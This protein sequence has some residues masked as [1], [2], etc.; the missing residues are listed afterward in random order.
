MGRLIGK[1]RAL[2]LIVEAANID[3]DRALELG[4]VNYV[5]EASS[6]EDFHAQVCDYARRF[7]PP[8][9]AS[10]AVGQIKR[11]VQSGLEMGLE[12]GLA[13][14]RELQAN[15]FRSSDAEEG[16]RAYLEKRKARFSGS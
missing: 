12:Q 13:F 10:L 2:Q 3:F 7:L 8:E 1:G 4:L 5:W 11:A 16:L 15:L 9:K 14:E 6:R